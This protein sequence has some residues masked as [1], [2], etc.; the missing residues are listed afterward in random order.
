MAKGAY[1]GVDGVARKIKKI[2]VGVDG[3]AREVKKAYVGIA[4][5]A[6][7]WLSKYLVLF[8]TTSSTHSSFGTINPFAGVDGN[9]WRFTI[10]YNLSSY[11][12]GNSRAKALVNIYDEDVALAGQTLSVSGIV[13]TPD[14]YSIAQIEFVDSSGTILSYKSYKGSTDGTSFTDTLTVPDGTE[15]IRMYIAAG[16]PGTN[17]KV[18]LI[19]NSV[20]LDGTELV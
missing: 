2:Y 10:E 6:R 7:Q 5:R 18:E 16:S 4:N 20:T 3:I 13:Y 17:K 19:L 8:S 11:V 1:I 12:T 9:T 14:T 15:T